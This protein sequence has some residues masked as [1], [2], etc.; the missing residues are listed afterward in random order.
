MSLPTKEIGNK[1]AIIFALVSFIFLFLIMGCLG[2][3]GKTCTGE[4]TVNG[5]K[6]NGT[7]KNPASAKRNTCAKYCI[8]G[9]SQMDAMYS[10]WFDS[11]S[12]RERKR[13]RKGVKGKWDAVYKSE[14]IKKYVVTCEQKCLRERTVSVKCDK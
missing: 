8:E 3:S 9:D 10:I 2:G 12:Q 6:Y 14:R 4:L 11:L 1:N 13:V 7:D 5:T